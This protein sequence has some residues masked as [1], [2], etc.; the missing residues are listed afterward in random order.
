MKCIIFSLVFFWRLFTA[1]NK[2]I[3][4]LV[5]IMLWVSL[6]SAHIMPF[7][8]LLSIYIYGFCV[9]QWNIGVKYLK[10]NAKEKNYS[11]LYD[12]RGTKRKKNT[13][14]NEKCPNSLKYHQFGQKMS[15]WNN[16]HR[17]KFLILFGLSGSCNLHIIHFECILAAMIVSEKHRA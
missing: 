1:L 7:F 14:E 11:S 10:V 4:V 16:P 6:C 8:W 9:K 12:A 17:S 2:K 15:N 5:F 3:V 13:S